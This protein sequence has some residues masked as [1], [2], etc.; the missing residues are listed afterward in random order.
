[1][2]L[3]NKAVAFAAAAVLAVGCFGL[4]ACG[5]SQ[6]AS[7]GDDKVIT[8][9][10]TPTPH[11][12]VLENAVAPILEEQGYDLQV[13]VFEDYVQPNTAVESGE[14]DA[15][16]FQH[17]NYLDAFNEENGTSLVNAG[18]VHYEPFGLYAGKSSDL[19]N[20]ADG[21][22]I[23][24]PND[25]TNE[26]RALLL[27]Q[28]EGLITLADGAGV[29][30]TTKD[31]V[32]NPK[33]LEIVELEAAQVSHSLQDVDFGIINGNYALEAGLS[34]A[35]ALAVESAEGVAAEQYGN[36]IAVADGNQDSEK[37]KALVAACQSDEV[38]KYIEDTYNGAVVPLT[39]S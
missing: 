34:V 30:A 4:T 6:E 23:A 16:Y 7:S 24:V 19:E 14:L 3:K 25:T 12:E 17:I 8:V 13:T 35:D 29:T 10:A 22:K 1:M 33:N 20:I 31:I 5:A 36:I 38:A 11:A 18:Y 27:L 28:Q 37:I 9:G 15:N 39:L 32:D 21:A 2:A 26:A